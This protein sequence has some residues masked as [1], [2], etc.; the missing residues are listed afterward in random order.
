MVTHDPLIT[1]YAKRL[2]YIRDGSI[3]TVLERND[4]DQDT[5]FSKIVEINSAESRE[6]LT[7]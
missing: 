1:S 2:L 5:F 4:M 6:L 7:K 3:D